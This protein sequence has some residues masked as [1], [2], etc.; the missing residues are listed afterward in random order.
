MSHEPRPPRLAIGITLVLIA[1]F[2]LAIA[3]C[4]VFI[5]RGKFPTIQ[6]I[7]IQ[8]F[9]SFFCILPWALRRGLEPLKTKELPTHLVR[10]FFGISSYYLF[11]LAIRFLN[12]VDATT[13]NY[14]A[15]FF[16]PFIWLVWMKQKV[17][18]HVWWSII[19]GFIGVAL[20]LNP[21]KSIFQ[22]GFVFGLFAGVTSAIALV[23]VRI[24]NLKME[25]MSRTL[26]YYFSFGSL[27]SFPFAW[28][29]WIPPT[30]EEW[31]FAVGIGVATAIGQIFL[32]IAY[33]YGTAAYLSPLGYSVVVYNGLISYFIFQDALGWH[34]LIGMC[35]IIVGGTL[36]FLWK[37]KAHP[38]KSGFESGNKPPPP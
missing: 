24:L 37:S 30:A 20:I 3:S 15:P 6:I 38:I 33:R 29:I 14:T 13:L 17:E 34:S 18:K 22:L 2:F 36:T 8:N 25:S 9:V 31:L 32:T 21:S 23:A 26:F 7:F 35:L 1:C 5:F 16:V 10:D 27:V 28:A 19:F 12:L 11:F 4:L